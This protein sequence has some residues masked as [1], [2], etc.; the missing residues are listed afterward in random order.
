MYE[1]KDEQI[2]ELERT[3]LGAWNCGTRMKR[4]M[5]EYSRRS[6]SIC[7]MVAFDFV[8]RASA[9][10]GHVIQEDDDMLHEGRGLLPISWGAPALQNRRESQV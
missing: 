3:A 5:K 7:L 8:R 4:G 6:R 1:E 2:P 9:D 10:E